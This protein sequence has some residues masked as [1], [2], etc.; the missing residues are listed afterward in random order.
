MEL[1]EKIIKQMVNDED[2]RVVELANNYG[3]P[4]R[5]VQEIINDV[6]AAAE[7]VLKPRGR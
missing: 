2:R 6:V 4:S 5:L 7:R 1:K 3:V